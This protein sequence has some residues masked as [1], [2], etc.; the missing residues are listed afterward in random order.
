MVMAI[1]QP[2]C[3]LRQKLVRIE[4]MCSWNMWQRN[5]FPHYDHVT[6]PPPPLPSTFFPIFTPSA[7]TSWFTPSRRIYT[8]IKLSEYREQKIHSLLSRERLL[9]WN[10]LFWLII[11]NKQHHNGAR[12]H[13]FQLGVL[14]APTP[15]PI[16]HLRFTS[17]NRYKRLIASSQTIFDRF[18]SFVTALTLC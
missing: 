5:E 16:P 7:F 8:A 18:S 17:G 11:L 2:S 1:L 3:Y 9:C 12:S 15:P 10:L 14:Q 4:N 6:S 13:E